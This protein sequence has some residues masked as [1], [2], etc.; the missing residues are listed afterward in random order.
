MSDVDLPVLQAQIMVQALMLRVLTK[1][2]RDPAE[3]RRLFSEE[4]DKLL[5]TLADDTLGFVT[6]HANTILLQIPK[7]APPSAWRNR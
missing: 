3:I 4:L 1:S 7:T 2:H 5:P 6:V